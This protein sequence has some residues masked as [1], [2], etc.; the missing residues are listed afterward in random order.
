MLGAYYSGKYDK[1]MMFMKKGKSNRSSPYEMSSISRI[2]EACNFEKGHEI[3]AFFNP[4]D[5]SISMKKEKEKT[6]R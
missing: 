6:H 4:S 5:S 3:S 2:K 1:A